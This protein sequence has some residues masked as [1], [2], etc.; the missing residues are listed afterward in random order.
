MAKIEEEIGDLLRQNNL[1]LGVVESATGGLISQRI[2]SVPGSSD[3]YKGSVTAYSNEI[4][5]RVV[6]V[7]RTTIS[8]QGAVSFL[9]AEEMAGEGRKFLGVDVCLSDTGIAGPGGATSGKPIGLFY[10][11]LAS[12]KG[13]SCQK[14]IFSGNREENKQNAAEAALKMLRSY[15]LERYGL[16]KSEGVLE[17]KQVV[18]CFLKS[19]KEILIL[20][21]SKQVGTYPG[22]W[23]GVSG[24][25]EKSPDEQAITEITEETGLSEEDIQLIRKGESLEI[26]DQ[27]IGRKWVV[28]PYLFQV[29]NR[30]KIKIDWEH[31]ELKWITPAEIARYDT[32]PMLKEV[33]ERVHEV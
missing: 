6:G 23:A 22:R 27:K 14:H 31:T 4:K 2:T 30:S 28:H 20:R 13:T 29:Q 25:V 3:Y 5:I 33:L 24:Y 1:T 8:G 26:V 7:K 15:L 32:V 9:T 11:G 17:E 18:T 21:R 19:G 10:L 12:E 16:G